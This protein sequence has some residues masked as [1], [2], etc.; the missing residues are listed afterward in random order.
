MTGNRV[1]LGDDY[2]GMGCDDCREA[3]SAA[4]D[5]EEQ[6]GAEAAVAAHLE[7]CAECRW[8]GERAARITRLTRTRAAEPAPDLVATVVAA[9]PPSRRRVGADAVRV[10]LGAVGIAQLGLAVSAIVDA[11]AHHG[12]DE[13]AGA[14]TAH[15]SNESSAWNAALAVAFLWAALGTTRVG[16][17][18]P[19]LAAFVGVLTALSVFDAVA[20]RVEFDRLLAHGLV[21]LGFLLLLASSRV[22]GDGGGAERLGE[23]GGRPTPVERSVAWLR[24]RRSDGDGLQPT[25]RHRAA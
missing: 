4:L 18:L 5:G 17:L 22:R 16:G 9:A 21:V 20:G 8:F 7:G 25:A 10:G 1:V 24:P 2:S 13:L 11:G 23:P 19:V 15:L 12:V 14:S 3:I 6:P